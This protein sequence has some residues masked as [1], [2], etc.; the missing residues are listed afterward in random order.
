[1][2]RSGGVLRKS[3]GG[4]GGNHLQDCCA[5][6]P[7]STTGSKLLQ[8][9]NRVIQVKALELLGTQPFEARRQNNLGG[10]VV[11]LHVSVMHGCRKAAAK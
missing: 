2:L 10:S 3:L 8:F 9:A 4:Q 11:H 7:A 1:M 6:A 5:C